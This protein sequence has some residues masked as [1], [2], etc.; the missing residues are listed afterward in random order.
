MSEFEIYRYL[1]DMKDIAIQYD[2]GKEIAEMVADT[3][4]RM[5]SK[6]YRVAVIGE[7]KRGK[8]SLIN[9]LVG[10]SILPTDIL[11]MTA[12]NTHLVY[13]A[14][15]K[16]DIF[17]KDGTIQESSVEQL[18]DFATK[19]D[20]QH[21]KTALKI[22]KIVVYYP[23]V[24]CKNH[25][26]II[27]T[28]GMND[29]QAMDTVTL[30]VLGQIDA[31]I[32]VVSA[33]MQ[34]SIT[35]QKLA[36]NLIQQQG[37]HHVVFVVTQIDRVSRR[38]KDQDRVI[39][40]I[41]QRISVDLLQKATDVFNDNPE[42]IKKARSI[43]ASPDIFGVS[44]VQ[45]MQGFTADDEELLKASRFP[46]FK[47]ELFDLLIAAQSTDIVL[48]AVDY[49]RIISENLS[50]W[51]KQ[52]TKNVKHEINQCAI[53]AQKS[54]YFMRSAKDVL[55]NSFLILDESLESKSILYSDS[56]GWINDAVEKGKVLFKKALAEIRKETD[57]DELIRSVLNDYCDKEWKSLC[58]N[59]PE[60]LPKHLIYSVGKNFEAF[61]ALLPNR[62]DADQRYEEWKKNASC[63]IHPLQQRD[64]IP[65]KP[66]S[67][68]L[69][70]LL[71][72]GYR[73]SCVTYVQSVKRHLSGYRTLMFQIYRAV[74]KAC[75]SSSAE[76]QMYSAEKRLKTLE[77]AFD[78]NQRKIAG[79]SDALGI[80]Q[81]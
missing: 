70:E 62:Q 22:Q 60:S 17:F 69:I 27:D 48:N 40:F 25:I 51:Y 32:M 54:K 73:H 53:S 64:Y 20:K 55:I 9:A 43:L 77:N 57:T 24:Y 15:K 72:E 26:E 49:S 45:A 3:A 13:G 80:I 6:I 19:Y 58:N 61:A 50:G 1:C 44:S 28:P 38:T 12:V 56:E 21:E 30:S 23:S 16:I 18:I 66:K 31:A 59:S 4:V 75:E 65:Q 78:Y 8:S 76:T 81:K 79:I 41:R 11:P 52:T 29:N 36:L 2:G 68:E 67:V 46:Q 74:M 47:Q 33:A 42:L 14:E 5:S 37:I 35:E 71:V 7:F 63:I 39:E 10:A 34:L